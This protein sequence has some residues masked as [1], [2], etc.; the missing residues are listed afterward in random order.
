MPRHKDKIT[1][2]LSVKIAP[3]HEGALEILRDVLTGIGF[4]RDEIIE[5]RQKKRSRL[6]LYFP[7][8]L[9]AEA[10]K[11]KLKKTP[12]KGITVSI[13]PLLPRDWRDRWKTDF[14]PFRLTEH[15]DVIPSWLKESGPVSPRR[16]VY[17][18]TSQA[19]G[20]GLHETTR[21][22]ASFIE[23]CRGEFKS[24]LDVG[25]GTGILSIVALHSGASRVRGIDISPESIKAAR[26]NLR[27]NGYVIGRQTAVDDTFDAS[28][29][30]RALALSLKAMDFEKFNEKTTYDFVAA[31]LITHDLIQMGKKIISLVKPGRYLA[32]SGISLE[33]YPLFRKTFGPFPLKRLRVEKGKSWV[34][35]LY[36]K[37]VHGLSRESRNTE[38]HKFKETSLVL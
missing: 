10:L 35:V 23:Q 1:F 20:T 13:K 4:K 17:I 14:K 26:F 9:K 18:D 22:M 32:V 24:F 12:L 27:T 37:T 30:R 29:R 3:S 7:S 31:N 21:F 16:P 15:L 5:L 36:K 8:P 28:G 2:E 6:C 11:E 19:F 38:A 25:T 33:N 34:G